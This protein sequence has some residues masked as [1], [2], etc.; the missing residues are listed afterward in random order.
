MVQAN[1]PARIY[2]K[3]I[4][5]TVETRITLALSPGRTIHFPSLYRIPLRIP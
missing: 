2:R 4:S 5:T 3:R 1:F